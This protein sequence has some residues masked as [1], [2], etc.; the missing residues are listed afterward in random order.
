M[1]EEQLDAAF[2]Q[3][4]FNFKKF[5]NANL[6]D[7]ETQ[8]GQIN[9]TEYT[10]IQQQLIDLQNLLE[11]KNEKLIA[12]IQGINETINNNVNK[13]DSEINLLKHKSDQVN[14]SLTQLNDSIPDFNIES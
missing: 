7:Y 3:D 5:I 8:N 10:K 1:D 9:P 13:M 6:T 12:N 14:S 11:L 2:A 4:K